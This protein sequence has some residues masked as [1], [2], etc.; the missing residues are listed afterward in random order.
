MS[1]LEDK[2]GELSD[3]VSIS[4][5]LVQDFTLDTDN[6]LEAFKTVAVEIASDL[7]CAETCETDA[8][9]HANVKFAFEKATKLLVDLKATKQKGDLA[10]IVSDAKSTV[11]QL[12]REINSLEFVQE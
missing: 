9:F 2:I 5:T 8:D 3:A 12:L 4:A 1:T 7:E 10:A 6:D 11:K